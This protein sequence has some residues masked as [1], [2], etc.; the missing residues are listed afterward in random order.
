MTFGCTYAQNTMKET[1]KVYKKYVLPSSSVDIDSSSISKDSE[2]RLAALMKPV[3]WPI[4][5][6]Y[7]YLDGKDTKPDEEWF[8]NLFTRFGWIS[9]VMMTDTTGAVLFQHPSVSLKDLQIQ[10]LLD[11]GDAWR[12]HKVRSKADITELGPEVYMASPLF[13]DGEW[14]GLLIVHFDPRKLVE[15]CTAP[16]DLIILSPSGVVWPGKNAEVANA[17]GQIEWDKVRKGRD[18]GSYS[19]GD[20]KFY[21]VAHDIGHFSLIYAAEAWTL[22]PPAKPA[23]G[24]APA[25]LEPASTD[26]EPVA[27]PAPESSPASVETPAPAPD[28]SKADKKKKKKKQ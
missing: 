12:D 24:Q 13:E 16:D 14:K 28:D 25:T 5:E 23:E 21:W 2:L 26:S 3:D 10:P 18:Y 1:K 8:Q 27:S 20:R 6:L 17:M 15:R 11:Y 4:F 9:G 19:N 22:E 7:R